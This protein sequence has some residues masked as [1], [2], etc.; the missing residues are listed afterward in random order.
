VP[1]RELLLHPDGEL[2]EVG[3]RVE[4]AADAGL[5][6]DHNQRI[7]EFLRCAAKVEDAGNPANL[8]GFVEI[9]DLMIDDAVTIE[10]EGSCWLR[11]GHFLR[12]SPNDFNVAS[13]AI[14]S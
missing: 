4:A 12:R 3:L 2:V 10:E 9:T 11:M 8:L 14:G 7:A 13:A 6:G 5:I 1:D